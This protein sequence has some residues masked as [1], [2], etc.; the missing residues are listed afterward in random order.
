LYNAMG[1]VIRV[2]TNQLYGA[3]EHT[4]FVNVSDL[5]AG[6]YFLHLESKGISKTKKL[7]KL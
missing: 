7:I 2:L 5:P 6:A 3:S 4:L 1:S